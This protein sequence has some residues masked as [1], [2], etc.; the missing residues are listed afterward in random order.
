MISANV[1]IQEKQRSY[2][3]ISFLILSFKLDFV[4]GGGARTIFDFFGASVLSHIVEFMSLKR[5]RLL[6][7]FHDL[8]MVI[9]NHSW[10]C[11]PWKSGFGLGRCGAILKLEPTHSVP[12][13][14]QCHTPEHEENFCSVISSEVIS[15]I[16]N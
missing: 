3:L 11:Q 8:K 12:P 5:R 2:I 6:L 7:D 15:N 14:F 4:F 10:L 16:L 13:H 9:C 1:N